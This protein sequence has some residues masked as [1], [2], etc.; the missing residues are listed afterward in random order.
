M[1]QYAARSEPVVGP[2]A[3]SWWENED[4]PRGWVNDRFYFQDRPRCD[5]LVLLYPLAERARL[6]PFPGKIAKIISQRQPVC[7][8]RYVGLLRG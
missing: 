2:A 6:K 8:E 3:P 4:F 1:P 5:H 7:R